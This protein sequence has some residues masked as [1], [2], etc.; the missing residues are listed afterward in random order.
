MAAIP[1]RLS[2]FKR[3]GIYYVTYYTNGKRRWKSTGVSTKP[4]AL[5]KLTEFREL[6]SKRRQTVNLSEFTERFLAFS[7]ANHRPKSVDLFRHTLGHFKSLMGDISVA[8]VTA[9][10]F[11]RY[12]TKRLM[13]KTERTKNPQE[14][15]PVSVNVELNMLR[16]AFTVAKR[17]GMIERNP[18]AECLL[19]T[20]PERAPSFF[21]AEDFDKLLSF[22]P[23]RW[24]REVVLFAALTGMRRGELL[25]LRWFNVNLS[26]K[27][28]TVQSSPTFKTKAGKMRIVPLNE[29]A[30]AVIRSRQGLSASEYV[31]TKNDAPIDEEWLTHA[32]KKAVV[33]AKLPAALHFH[34]LRH[35]FASWLVQRGATLYQ[36][37]ALLGH[38]SSQMTEVYSHLQPEQLHKTV[39]RI[40]I[41]VN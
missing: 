6:L 18:F 21:T 30:L 26:R 15:S 8:E 19:C 33:K 27:T 5:K 20:V 25:N 24:L 16:A 4:E 7:S 23:G 38:S 14:R 37:Q 31:F 13:E 3:F 2:L 9:E 34:S 41:S 11:D 1:D 12:K 29:A 40:N 17:W 32:F 35:T 22:L 10:H 39:N 28:V 36:V